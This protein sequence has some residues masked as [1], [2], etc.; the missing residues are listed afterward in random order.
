MMRERS[1]RWIEEELARVSEQLGAAQ[2]LERAAQERHGEEDTPEAERLRE[3]RSR[4]VGELNQR[5]VEE[6]GWS[7]DRAEGGEAPPGCRR[8]GR[9]RIGPHPLLPE[10]GYIIHDRTEATVAWVR[11]VPSPARAA[12][13]LAEHGIEWEGDRCPTRSRPCR[14]R[15]RGD[16]RNYR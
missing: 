14:R 10:R 8:A 9:L 16:G 4:L 2:D 7:P 1:T 11:G 13:L 6:K 15:R 12:E 5:A 3:Q